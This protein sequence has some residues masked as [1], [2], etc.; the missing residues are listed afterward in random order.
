MANGSLASYRFVL[1]NFANSNKTVTLEAESA[2]GYPVSLRTVNGVTKSPDGTYSLAVP[3]NGSGTVLV[4]CEVPEDAADGT[5][6]RVTLKV[7]DNSTGT[8]IQSLSLIHI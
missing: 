6:S 3:A 2:D 5:V 1:Q 8:L 4:D 7:L